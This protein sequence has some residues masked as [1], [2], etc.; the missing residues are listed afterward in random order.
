MGYAGAMRRG[1]AVC[2]GQGR[3]VD[4]AVQ[5][6]PGERLQGPRRDAPA[7]PKVKELI[8]DEGYDADWYREELT[9]RRIHICYDRCANI[10]MSAIC[11]AATVIFWL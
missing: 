10:F 3:A 11:I 1:N 8:C 7:L 6:R 5:R 4:H 2:D 9:K